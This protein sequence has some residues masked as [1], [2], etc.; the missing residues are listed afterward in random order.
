MRYKYVQRGT[1]L[2]HGQQYYYTT[3]K[4]Y[5]NIHK[6]CSLVKSCP[7]AGCQVNDAAERLGDT[8]P[9]PHGGEDDLSSSQT[10]VILQNTSADIAADSRGRFT[11]FLLSPLPWRQDQRLLFLYQLL[12]GSLLNQLQTPE[13][14]SRTCMMLQTFHIEVN[15][16]RQT[17]KIIV[18]TSTC[19]PARHTQSP[20]ALLTCLPE[21]SLL[22]HPSPSP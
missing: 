6:D 18:I 5:L 13:N 14:L 2:K 3:E 22:N 8:R 15:R 19:A 12:P 4:E 11:L 7:A 10:A 20:Q 21:L 16:I 1:R 17:G 9:N